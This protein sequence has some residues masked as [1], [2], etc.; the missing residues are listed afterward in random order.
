MKSTTLKDLFAKPDIRF[1]IPEYQRAYTWGERQFSQFVED[2]MECGKNYFLGHF[3][4]EKSENTLYIIDGQQRLT[5]CVIFFSV[6]MNAIRHRQDESINA[7]NADD[8][9]G[10]LNN[11]T[12]RYLKDNTSN[13]LKFTTVSYDNIFFIDAIIEYKESVHEEELTSKSRLAMRNAR[14]Y[15][16]NEMSKVSVPQMLSW[17]DTLENASLTTFIVKDKI[18]AAQIFAC[19][20]DRGK[21]LT[22]L[23]VLKA[24]FM[25]QLFRQ[26]NDSDGTA[27]IE[28]AFEEI[29]RNI[30]LITVDEDNVLNYYWKATGPNGYYSD[31]VVSEDKD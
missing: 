16:E 21:K 18:Q 10:L 2:L 5:T 19:Q 17:A 20:N 30:V 23:E 13:R 4:F 7:G 11:I 29:Y 6:L 26:G 15:F 24:Y 31:K 8:I 9:T 28:N 3:L 12:D 14:A 1:V 27:Y 22:N 25:L